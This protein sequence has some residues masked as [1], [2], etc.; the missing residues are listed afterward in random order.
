MV[1]SDSMGSVL[2]PWSRLLVLKAP[3]ENYTRP[4]EFVIF[5]KK[6]MRNLAHRMANKLMKVI[7]LQLVNF[8]PTNAVWFDST[9]FLLFQ[10]FAVSNFC[11][12]S[13]GGSYAH[14]GCLEECGIAALHVYKLQWGGLHLGLSGVMHV[15]SLTLLAT[16]PAYIYLCYIWSVITDG[17]DKAVVFRPRIPWG[18]SLYIRRVVG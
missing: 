9:P 12:W 2:K 17:A 11:F 8:P 3:L 16:C 15:P 5:S 4:Q 13:V 18:L 10:C 7:S 14:A 1:V 6:I